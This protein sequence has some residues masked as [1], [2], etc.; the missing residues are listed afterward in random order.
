MEIMTGDESWLFLHYPHDSAWIASRDELPVQIKP[1]I[2]A[3]KCL[4]LV[5]W[6]VHEIH[7]LVD[8]PKGASY[9][10]AFFYDVVVPS[11]IADIGSHSGRKSLKCLYV[12]LDNARPHN[13]RQSID[14]LQATKARRMAQSAYSP[15]LTPSDFFLFGYLK[16]KLQEV[17]I[18]D[19]E[20]LKSEIIQILDGIGRDVLISMLE[21]WMKRLE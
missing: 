14:C 20:R 4:I 8:V 5:I 17:H 3:E 1:E 16:Q 15:G 12:H 13:S 9:K 21:D 18:P 2:E 6:P 19:R 7:I 10:S 11:L